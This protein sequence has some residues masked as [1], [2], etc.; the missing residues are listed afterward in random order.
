VS[1][2]HSPF[3]AT[4]VVDTIVSIGPDAGIEPWRL[5]KVGG[6]KRELQLDAYTTDLRARTTPTSAR[7]P[8]FVTG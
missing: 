5:R 2:R 3:T 4:T 6:W 8:S 7:L 1:D